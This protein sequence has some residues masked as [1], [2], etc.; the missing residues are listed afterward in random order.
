MHDCGGRSATY[1]GGPKTA[2]G[3]ER[4]RT[5]ALVHGRRTREFIETGRALRA[6]LRAQV[7]RYAAAVLKRDEP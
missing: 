1:A 6:E 7:A 2:E 4:S 3:L 5:T